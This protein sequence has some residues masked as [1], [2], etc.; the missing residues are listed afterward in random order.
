MRGLNQ[1]KGPEAMDL[2]QQTVHYRYDS[3]GPAG[4]L[5]G[6]VILTNSELSLPM[7][8]HKGDYIGAPF[9]NATVTSVK[10][11]YQ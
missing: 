2:I 6:N 4:P 11:T 3:P 8:Y 10:N 5:K 7:I 1:L 9:G